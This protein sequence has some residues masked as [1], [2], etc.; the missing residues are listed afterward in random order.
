MFAIYLMGYR[1]FALK[2]CTKEKKDFGLLNFRRE[3][4]LYKS[5]RVIYQTELVI[6]DYRIVRCRV[7]T[8]Q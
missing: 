1:Y 6:Q 3:I 2:G 5:F 4:I 7:V 8:N